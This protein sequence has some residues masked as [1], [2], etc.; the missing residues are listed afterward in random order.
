[1]CV[2]L[3]IASEFLPVS[4][5][6]PIARDLHATEG[7]AGQAIST[8]GLFAVIAS[9]LIATVA[10]HFDRRNLLLG[11]T[12]AMLASLATVAM[13]K[14]FVVL[15]VG[16]ALLGVVIGGFWALAVS[17]VLRLVPSGSNSVSKALGIV[18]SGNAIATAFAPPLG[19]YF[20]A[21]V[22][23]RGVFWGMVPLA[24]ICLV[25][26]W[27]S[28][29]SIPPDRA[30]PLGEVLQ[31][32]KRKSV[33]VA[34]LAAMLTWSGGMA[35][36][37]YFRPFLE[38]R[39]RVD[40]TQLSLLLLALGLAG[41]VG[42]YLGGALADRYLTKLMS[43]LPMGLALVTLGLLAVGQSVPLVAVGLFVWGVLNSTIPVAWSTWQTVGFADQPEAGGGL[44]VAAIQ[45]SILVG[46]ALGGILLDHISITASFLAGAVL[47]IL[48]TVT[49]GDGTRVLPGYDRCNGEV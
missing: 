47:L 11:L 42:T 32:L 5:L 41:F 6:T 26:Q 7:M 28:L 1:M 14:S 17:T 4:L 30:I 33:R 23:W 15:I 48:A 36:F 29:P 19:S 25:W 2:G 31:L 37:T 27:A 3:L 38:T 12:A 21:I 20:G 35:A 18:Y 40:S 9:L 45:L 8:S 43:L 49:V 13:A 34:S 39:T 46:G 44:M 10:S 24:V 16:R 22:G